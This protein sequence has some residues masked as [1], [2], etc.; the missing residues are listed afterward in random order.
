MLNG[1]KLQVML[2]DTQSSKSSGVMQRSKTFI[3][4]SCVVLFAVT[5]QHLSVGDAS[6]INAPVGTADANCDTTKPAGSACVLA[7][8][9]LKI[10]AGSTPSQ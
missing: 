6:R 7:I 1:R 4:A 3:L 9:A 10:A 2:C 8:S 5:P